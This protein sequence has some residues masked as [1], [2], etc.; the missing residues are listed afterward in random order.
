[1]KDDSNELFN[2]MKQLSGCEMNMHI[3]PRWAD[4][5]ESS[6]VYWVNPISQ[7]LQIEFGGPYDR[8]SLIEWAAARCCYRLEPK[9]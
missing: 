7:R 4:E 8:D 5:Q 6:I 2:E 3:S 1:M 9:E